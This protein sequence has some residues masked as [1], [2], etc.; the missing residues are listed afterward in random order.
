MTCTN[1]GKQAWRIANALHASSQNIHGD[2]R[3]LIRAEMD[4][5]FTHISGS[6]INPKRVLTIRSGTTKSAT[7]D[8]KP[9]QVGRWILRVRSRPSRHRQTGCSEVLEPLQR[10]PLAIAREKS[11]IPASPIWLLLRY[12]ACKAPQRPTG[13]FV[14]S[15]NLSHSSY[16]L[17]IYCLEAVKEARNL[18]EFKNF[19]VERGKRRRNGTFYLKRKNLEA[20]EAEKFV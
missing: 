18:E 20:V 1:Q 7:V 14:K 12:S 2:Y 13:D 6:L 17:R 15:R 8:C 4:D 5:P 3:V 16:R 19:E 9:L 10:D 11:A